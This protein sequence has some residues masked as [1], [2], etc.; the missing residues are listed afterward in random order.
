MA[1]GGERAGS[2][3]GGAEIS[4]AR[5][6]GDVIERC[7]LEKASRGETWEPAA[8]SSC[9]W[10]KRLERMESVST[11]KTHKQLGAYTNI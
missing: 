7:W 9:A 11:A 2:S 6:E 4:N 3:G 5:K 10:G 1:T 8:A